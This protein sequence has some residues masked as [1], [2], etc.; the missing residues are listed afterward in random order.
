MAGSKLVQKIDLETGVIYSEEYWSGTD[1]H[2]KEADG[3]AVIHRNSQTGELMQEVYYLRGKRHRIEGPALVKRDLHERGILRELWYREGKQVC[4]SADG[5]EQI[6]ESNPEIGSSVDDGLKGKPQC[7]LVQKIA[8]KTG[9]LYSEEYFSG[10][11]RHRE[12]TDGPAMIRWDEKTGVVGME[13]YYR[14]SK[15]HR[16][17]GPALILYNDD[18]KIC[19]EEYYREG[20]LHRDPAEGPA[21]IERLSESDPSLITTVEYRLFGEPHRP[22][23]AGPWRIVFCEDTGR[24][25]E[26]EFCIIDATGGL[27]PTPKA[28]PAALFV[29]SPAPSSAP[30]VAPSH[31]SRPVPSASQPTRPGAAGA[32][33]GPSSGKFSR[34]LPGLSR[35]WR[36]LPR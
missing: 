8:L 7:R 12:E 3:P 24:I 16:K 21:V 17:E 35:L 25:K 28:A 14:R 4:D 36:F 29:N 5:S 23:T 34:F 19:R 20:K 31:A 27:R 6:G 10:S 1:R 32:A 30:P 15:L 13:R 33:K 11:T 2:R 9:I 26:R 22:P 18:G